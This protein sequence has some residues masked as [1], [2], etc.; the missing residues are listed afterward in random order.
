M[1]QSF[2]LL[3]SLV[4]GQRSVVLEEGVKVRSPY[5]QTQV[6]LKVPGSST[7]QNIV[8]L[9]TLGPTSALAAIRYM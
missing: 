4:Q 7:F 2:D 1:L 6:I 5:V 3:L 8:S 9:A